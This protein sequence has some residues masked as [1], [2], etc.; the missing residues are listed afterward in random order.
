MQRRRLLRI[1]TTVPFLS[2]LGLSGLAEAQARRR[3]RPADAAWPSASDW[4]RLNEDVGGNLIDVPPLFAACETAPRS[5]ACI[6][7]LEHVGNPYWLGDQPAGT[8]LSGWLD[9]WSPS[10]S[11]YA[12]RAH[13][14]AHVAAA[15]NFARE[16]EIGRANGSACAEIAARIA[17][18]VAG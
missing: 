5:A 3:S 17:C 7:A 14:A 1:A 13:S 2:G 8:E 10:P 16:H 11:A 4:Q 6:D 18:S 12:V 15:V 9:A